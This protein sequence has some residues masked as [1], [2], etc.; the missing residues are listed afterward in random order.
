MKLYD[1][2]ILGAGPCGI[3]TSIILKE[4][5][6]DVAVIEGYTPGGKIN[7]A[8]RV[9]NYPGYTKISGPDLAFEFFKKMNEAHVEMISTKV[10]KL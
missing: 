3:R 8:P 2:L 9:D 1:T 10:N 5:G 7:I 4:A 6:L